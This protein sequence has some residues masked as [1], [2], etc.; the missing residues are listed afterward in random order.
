M[1][2]FINNQ[3]F[4]MLFGKAGDGVEQSFDEELNCEKD[5]E[6]RIVDKNPATNRF[7]SSV[8]EDGGQGDNCAS[9][10]AGIIEGIL[11]ANNMSCKCMAHFVPDEDDDAQEAETGYS[12]EGLGTKS[13]KTTKTFT[14]LYV[15]KFDQDVTLRDKKADE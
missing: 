13:K 8:G 2:Q 3:I 9:F 5:D 6:Y 15:I 12:D 1:L 10:I 11:T 4:K 7:I 14:T